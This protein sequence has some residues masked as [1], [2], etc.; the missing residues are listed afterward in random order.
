MP[1]KDIYSS[2][3]S[4]P[5]KPVHRRPRAGHAYDPTPPRREEEPPSYTEDEPRGPSNPHAG[6][7]DPSRAY[8]P[9][10][11][12][13]YRNPG[14]YD[15]RGRGDWPECEGTCL[16]GKCQ[17]DKARPGCCHLARGGRGS[18]GGQGY[19]A[20]AGAGGAGDTAVS[21]S[22]VAAASLYK[23]EGADGLVCWDGEG[24]V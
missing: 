8:Y 22:S 17:L 24:A 3:H 11:G 23:R 5:E 18:Y 7:E 20:S 4:H 6:E 12:P 21:S 19:A 15:D 16:A 14:S 1:P 10:E 9:T 13:S 2:D